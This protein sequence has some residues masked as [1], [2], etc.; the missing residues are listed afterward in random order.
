ML[1]I[2]F[3]FLLI[4]IIVLAISFLFHWSSSIIFKLHLQYKHDIK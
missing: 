2:F 4:F 3:A 1:N